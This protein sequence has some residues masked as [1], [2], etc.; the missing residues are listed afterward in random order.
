MLRINIYELDQTYNIT[1]NDYNIM[2][3]DTTN[4][5]HK[6]HVSLV[7]YASKIARW[8]DLS[9]NHCIKTTKKEKHTILR[10]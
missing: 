8:I 9:N 2:Y 6:F 4:R 5:R 10:M 1:T 7:K 3:L